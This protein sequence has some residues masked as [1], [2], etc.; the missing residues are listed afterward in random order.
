MRYP[1]ILSNAWRWSVDTK[2][3]SCATGD[4]TPWHKTAI[5]VIIQFTMYLPDLG[6]KPDWQ[7]ARWV[8]Y[9]LDHR[10][11][12]NMPEATKIFAAWHEC[13]KGKKSQSHKGDRGWIYF[14][15]ILSTWFACDLCNTYLTTEG[16]TT[17]R[18]LQRFLLLSMNAPLIQWQE[19]VIAACPFHIC[20]SGSYN[21]LGAI[22]NRPSLSRY[23]P[24]L[25]IWWSQYDPGWLMWTLNN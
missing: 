17:C 4:R 2:V 19:W 15:C 22:D 7:C 10:G 24:Q 12:F 21:N 6:L 3:L 16:D 18:K 14:H 1:V 11:R 25:Y 9:L 13:F 5:I 8:C 20:P 23:I